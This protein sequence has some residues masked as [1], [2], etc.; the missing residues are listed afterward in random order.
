M[1]T[2]R[3]IKS[4]LVITLALILVTIFLPQN[5]SAWGNAEAHPEINRLAIKLLQQ[6]ANSDP[7]LAALKNTSLDG[8]SCWGM[9]WDAVDGN[10]L[11]QRKPS[12]SRQ[13]TLVNWIIDGG[14]SADEPEGPAA[15]RHFYDPVNKGHLTD[16]D[17]I[18]G[19]LRLTLGSQAVNPE[20][21]AV[22]WAMNEDEGVGKMD[23]F[24]SQDYSYPDAKEYF[25]KALA[26]KSR[27]NPNYGNAWRA[28]GETMHLVADMGLAPHVRNDGHG[29]GDADPVE[30]AT[31]A[32]II[33]QYNNTNWTSSIYYNQ[34]IKGLM[35]ELATYTNKNFFSKDTIP[36]TGKTT[37]ANGQ[38]AYSSPSIGSLTVS[39]SG[40]LEG[41]V[42]GVTVKLARQ[43]GWYRWGLSKNP[44]YVIDDA[45][46]KDQQRILIPTIIRASEAVLEIFL[47][48]FE[49]R[50]SVKPDP[51]VAGR[52]TVIGE[53]NLKPSAEWS[54]R[55]IIR[56]GAYVVLNGKKETVKL[57]N[58]D[59][60]NEFSYSITGKAGDQ[61]Q[62]IY[63]LGGYVIKSEIVKIGD[64]TIDP[65]TLSGETNKDYTFKAVST[66]TPANAKYE[67]LVNESSK[68]KDASASFTTRFTAQGDYTVKAKLLDSAGKEVAMTT[69]KVTIKPAALK[70][71]DLV[72]KPGEYPQGFSAKNVYEKI[73]SPT[74]DPNRIPDIVQY[75]FEKRQAQN[76]GDWTL[77]LDTRIRYEGKEVFYY[78]KGVGVE[79]AKILFQE[80]VNYL[81]THATGK[82]LTTLRK[83]ANFCQ[84]REERITTGAAEDFVYYGVA[85]VDQYVF[86]YQITTWQ[87]LPNTY[88][89]P[90]VLYPP[91]PDQAYTTQRYAAMDKNATAGNQ[92]MEQILRSKY[93][94]K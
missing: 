41:K 35:H 19:F 36:V 34:G 60:L 2:R 8:D 24:F 63:D 42:D 66:S 88:K 25:K 77:T 74:G 44:G 82:K 73:T 48:R 87:S 93:G 85:R 33:S 38:P 81:E 9:A 27:D 70:L 26:D 72:L 46:I 78:E 92:M 11:I 4:T 1:E 30:G 68:Q 76:A 58:Q 80:K 10:A 94:V 14:Y 84:Y 32:A 21:S 56:N 79:G 53:I 28:V 59:N 55:L 43:S 52:Y 22:E 16:T 75:T 3:F 54:E 6:R 29:L 51:D 57:V 67:W 50:A 69:S 12:T 90:S 7:A 89:D 13:K 45:V 49:A 5:V 17:W 31:T 47:P 61:V 62:V 39:K 71:M 37:T 18:A 40:Y 20:I 86:N 64:L 83:D 91:L 23:V 65:A 15:L